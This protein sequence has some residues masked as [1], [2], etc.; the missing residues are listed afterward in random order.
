M[1]QIVPRTVCEPLST[2]EPTERSKHEDVGCRDEHAH[3]FVSNSI[4]G[5]GQRAECEKTKNRADPTQSV[6]EPPEQRLLSKHLLKGQVT[7]RSSHCRRER[8]E[9]RNLRVCEIDTRRQPI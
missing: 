8:G 5:A 4:K 2:D 7:K 3:Q 9:F 1:T 6:G